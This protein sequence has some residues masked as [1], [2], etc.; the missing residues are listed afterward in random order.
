MMPKVSIIIAC[1]NDPYIQCAVESAIAQD[2]ENKE[3]ILVDDGS[4]GRFKNLVSSLSKEVDIFIQQPNAG[5]S[6]ARNNAIKRA[7]GNYI[8]NH[9]SDDFF[10]KSF[11]AKAVQIFENKTEV[12][13]VTCKANRIYE[14][15]IVDVYTPAG[16]NYKN[17]LYS[18]AALGSSMFRKEDWG[19]CGGYEEER[20]VLGFEDWELYLNILKR[21]GTTYV[22]DEVLFNYRLRENSITRRI[23][24]LRNEK[25]KH[26]ILKH[27]EL[28]IEQFETTINNLFS[29]MDNMQREKEKLIQSLEYKTGNRMLRPLRYIKRIF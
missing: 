11:S 12:K 1:Y 19:K 13:I 7:S 23:S 22:L 28:Y 10:E 27:Q 9:D 5:Q 2:Y 6:I 14:D 20:P 8:L 3:I 15:E 17:F 18:N 16:G 24:S 29:R 25:Y 21:G 4:E 26:I